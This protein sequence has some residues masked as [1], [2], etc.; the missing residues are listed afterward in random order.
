MDSKQT[1]VPDMIL[2]AA[3]LWP[4]LQDFV[5]PKTL[6]RFC[7]RLT[8]TKHD[9]LTGGV[10]LGPH[11]DRNSSESHNEKAAVEV[12]KTLKTMLTFV[13]WLFVVSNSEM[14]WLP[15][16]SHDSPAGEIWTG[17]SQRV[18]RITWK[19]IFVF[20]SDLPTSMPAGLP[21]FKIPRNTM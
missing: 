12:W 19:P 18:F 11:S 14:K 20:K 16:G 15:C 5:L 4:C 2:I 21:V 6:S 8:M 9:C 13:R 1:S 10:F 3:Y 7:P 17:N